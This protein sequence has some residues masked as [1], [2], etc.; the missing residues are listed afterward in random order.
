M[1]RVKWKF[2]LVKTKGIDQKVLNVIS[3]RSAVVTP[4]FVTNK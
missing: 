3:S 4:S 1:S 2:P